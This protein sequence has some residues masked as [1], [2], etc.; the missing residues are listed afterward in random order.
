MLAKYC[1][2]IVFIYENILKHLPTS[3]STFCFHKHLF[4]PA[5]RSKKKKYKG[6]EDII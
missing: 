4:Y 6:N 5:F 3:I 1:C 2:V